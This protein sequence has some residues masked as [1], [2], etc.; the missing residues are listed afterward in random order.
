MIPQV[1][2]Q[3]RTESL[4]L[5]SP[6]TKKKREWEASTC[7]IIGH[8]IS[9]L[10]QDAVKYGGVSWRTYAGEDVDLK[11]YNHLHQNGAVYHFH[12]SSPDLQWKETWTFDIENLTIVGSN[13]S[14]V[15]ICLGPGESKTICL[16]RTGRK[17]WK[18]GASISNL[19]ILKE[20]ATN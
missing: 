10:I 4:V 6:M 2:L 19:T 13:N 8:S 15:E 7:T 17:E 14:C 12:N 3:P 5:I 18:V 11:V 1:V 9:R 20:Q 16:E